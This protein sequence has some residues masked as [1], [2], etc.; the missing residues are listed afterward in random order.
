MSAE[1]RSI[2]DVFQNIVRNVQ[3][4]VRSEIRLAKN[5]VREEAVKAKSATLLLGIGTFASIFSIFFLLLALVYALARVIPNWGAAL[6]VGFV[7]ALIA[8]LILVK[9]VRRLKQLSPKPEHTVETMKE[10]IAW[11][12]QQTRLKHTSRTRAKS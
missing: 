5:E 7:L 6:I 2:S 9:G 8:C 11:A 10:N 3:E 1:G 12:K 4:I